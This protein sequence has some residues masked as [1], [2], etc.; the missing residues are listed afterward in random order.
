MNA[1]TTH[2]GNTTHD[3][4]TGA[5]G[6]VELYIEIRHLVDELGRLAGHISDLSNTRQRGL[7]F[8]TY[9]GRVALDRQTREERRIRDWNASNR[10]PAPAGDNPAPGNLTAIR[11]DAE[12]TF[13]LKHCARQLIRSLT[14][15]RVCAL[16]R[17]PANPNLA[18]YLTHVYELAWLAR[19]SHDTSTL[20]AVA[21]D[22]TNARDSATLVVDG[23][24]RVLLED[25]CPHCGNRTLV[26][27]FTDDTIRCGRDPKT[28]A[29]MRCRCTV[30]NCPCQT[31]PVTNRHEWHRVRGN[32]WYL[33]Q[34]DLKTAKANRA[35]AELA[36]TPT[37]EEEPPSS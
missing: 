14:R 18:D 24:D 36:K 37:Q 17:L 7:G 16:H 22:L 3:D 20:T 5:P 4:P 32:G 12:L 19:L 31:N 21:R 33:L 9:E 29:Y 30:D 35:A 1:P 10:F 8:L 34:S 11:A 25:P 28:G 15:N 23:N 26:V 13:T 27:T 2:S 6:A